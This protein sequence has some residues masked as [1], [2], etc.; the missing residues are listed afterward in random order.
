[1]RGGNRAARLTGR[2]S[3]ISEHG[4]W[5]GGETAFVRFHNIN[6]DEILERLDSFRTFN[7]FFYRNLRPGAR[8]VASPDPAVAVCAADSR[9]MAF[10][11]VDEAT[12]YTLAGATS[13]AGVILGKVP[14]SKRS[15]GIADACW[16]PAS[17]APARPSSRLW[18]KGQEFSLEALL[19]DAKLA[20]YFAGGSLA[21]FRYGAMAPACARGQRR[22]RPRTW[23]M[24]LTAPAISHRP[25]LFSLG[26]V[27]SLAVGYDGCG[28]V[29]QASTSRLPSLPFASGRGCGPR[30]RCAWN[31]LHGQPDGGARPRR[32][33]IHGKQARRDQHSVPAVPPRKRPTA[34][35]ARAKLTLTRV[36]E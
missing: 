3:A 13:P 12:R 34:A 8:V 32:Q 25:R 33:R 30:A 21:I 14:C 22:R 20:Q 23:P 7:Q 18:I 16:G 10:S 35:A 28:R 29:W 6:T 17:T 24:V 27:C 36:R 5:D 26:M 11:T 2:V 31:L 15:R 4:R 1:M 9:M 19:D